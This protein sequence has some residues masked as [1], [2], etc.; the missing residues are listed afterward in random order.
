MRDYSYYS[1]LNFSIERDYFDEEGEWIKD[2]DDIGWF[3]VDE[4]KMIKAAVDFDNKVESG[5]VDYPDCY[6][7]LLH[8]QWY[9]FQNG[10]D[11]AVA[12]HDELIPDDY[13]EEMGFV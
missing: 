8:Q 4:E 3:L 12:Y 2:A 6:D 5:K 7:Y 10:K 11:P 1:S 9:V 13:R